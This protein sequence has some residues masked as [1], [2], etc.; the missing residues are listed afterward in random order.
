MTRACI[1]WTLMFA[2]VAACGGSSGTGPDLSGTWNATNFE[3]VSVASPGTKVELVAAGGHAVLVLKADKSYTVTSAPP[4]GGD[5]TTSGTWTSSS[6]VLTLRET[7]IGGDMQFAYTLSGNT[8][9]LTGADGE[10]D[11]DGDGA[12]EPAKMNVTATRG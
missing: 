7:G 8:L 11:F 2:L 3:F 5:T 6:D 10:F 9:T 1:G 4:G 12:M